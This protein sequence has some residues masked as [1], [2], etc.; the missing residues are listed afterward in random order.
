MPLDLGRLPPWTPLAALA[1]GGVG[2][3][4]LSQWLRPPVLVPE[5]SN[6]TGGD[7]EAVARDP[8]R[9]TV[10]GVYPGDAPPNDQVSIEIR[11][12][13]VSRP[14]TDREAAVRDALRI[15]LSRGY[16]ARLDVREGMGSGWRVGDQGFPP[17]ERATLY[18][19][20]LDSGTQ[21]GIPVELAPGM[22][23]FGENT[24][25][26][27]RA[28]SA[29]RRDGVVQLAPGQRLIVVVREAPMPGA[30]FVLEK[31]FRDLGWSTLASAPVPTD[32][33]DLYFVVVD[34]L[35]PEPGAQQRAVPA[36]IS[37]SREVVRVRSS[38]A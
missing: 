21:A 9:L 38:M 27:S 32:R 12:P 10:R 17:V 20:V 31:D 7:A 13:G 34:V 15:L 22:V 37:S 1:A 23:V 30:N 29:V 24:P 3:W 33:T 25:P 28:P 36:R 8:E 14:G 4:L 26:P 18:L 6:L 16:V 11:R 5:G 35:G 19:Q 2:L